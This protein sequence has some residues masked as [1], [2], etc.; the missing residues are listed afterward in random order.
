MAE[1]VPARSVQKLF[2]RAQGLH[3]DPRRRL[4][5]A[6][7]ARAI[8]QLGYLQVDSINVV[9]RAHHL[10]LGARFDDYSPRVLARLTEERRGLFEH[11]TH[12]ASLVPIAFFCHWKHRF[13]SWKAVM[14]ARPRWKKRLG[15]DPDGT[16]ARVRDRI[17]KE[18]PLQ[19]RDFESRHKGGGWW[20]WKPEKTALE[21][22]WRSGELGIRGRDNFAKI[23]DLMERIHPEEHCSD[24]PESWETR[25]WLCREALERLV[26]ATPG[27]IARFFEGLSPSEARA[28]CAD[29]LAA[30]EIVPVQIADAGSGRPWKAYAVSDWR[31]RLDRAGEA[32]RRIR[33]L[34]PFDP[35]LR[36][37][38]R[39]HRVFGF[40]YRIETFVPAARR[41]YGYYV[42][43]IL[44]G[45]RFKGRF[46]PKLHRS[47]G[48]LEVKG[49]WWEPGVEQTANR[50]RAFERSLERL[51]G[52][53][54]AQSIEIS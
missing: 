44:E 20:D 8:H 13:E 12:D 35:I 1:V 39:L 28:W 14:A 21:Y 45:G 26:I 31:K 54:G 16:L 19:S 18:G 29:A 25:N 53:I 3:E 24:A 10:T 7:L 9:E 46:E 52:Q 42:M 17:A 51:A 5:T 11:W 34:T 41:E 38:R 43:P 37:R 33:L 47:A 15:P 36:D 6:S 32:P 27:E 48:V 4:T 2:M 40:D 23:Y 22:L 50:M 49:I 30:E